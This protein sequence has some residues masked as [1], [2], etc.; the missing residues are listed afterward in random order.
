[1]IR[2]CRSGAHRQPRARG[3]S[4]LLLPYP[5][6]SAGVGGT[7]ARRTAARRHAQGCLRTGCSARACAPALSTPAC[8]TACS[9]KAVGC[10][11]WWPCASIRAA[12]ATLISDE[13]ADCRDAALKEVDEDGAYLQFASP[14]SRRPRRRTRSQTPPEDTQL[15]SAWRSATAGSARLSSLAW[16]RS[17]CPPVVDPTVP[18]RGSQ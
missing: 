18:V 7:P 6:A 8:S 5:Q 16:G 1:M 17:L 14:A 9:T 2:T 10:R 15:V 12:S 3:S 4:V 11:S 13:P